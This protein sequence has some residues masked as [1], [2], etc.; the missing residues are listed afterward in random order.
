MVKIRASVILTDLIKILCILKQKDHQTS[1]GTTG[2]VSD[3]K[4]NLNGHSNGTTEKED[5]DE[6]QYLDLI[7]KIMK[8]GEQM[9][10]S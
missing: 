5:H 2:I 6:D 1:N 9:K 3:L 4:N 7:R 8:K 10:P